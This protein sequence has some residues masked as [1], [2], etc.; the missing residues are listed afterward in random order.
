MVAGELL[1]CTR[2]TMENG[3][4]RVLT[5]DIYYTTFGVEITDNLA[6]RNIKPG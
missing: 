1:T 4:S 5:H 2:A 3:V 6:H